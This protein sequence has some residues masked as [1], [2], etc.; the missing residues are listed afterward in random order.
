M[1]R[2]RPFEAIDMLS[3][4]AESKKHQTPGMLFFENAIGFHFKSY[5][6]LLASTDTIAR[7]VVALYK[8]QPAN[9][10]DGKGNRD[11]IKEMQT[12]QS[13]TINSQFD[14]LKNLRNGVYN[15][16]VVTHDSFNKSF[17]GFKTFG[18]K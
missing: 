3:K 9:I 16:R 6:S 2:I 14:T 8:S 7:P 13:F 15:S 5:E 18:F 1:P 4:S 11:V 12:V 17:T 10:R